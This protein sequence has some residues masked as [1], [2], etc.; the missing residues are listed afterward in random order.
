MSNS[1]YAV[2][3]STARFI[4]LVKTCLSKSDINVAVQKPIP[5]ALRKV[6]ELDN[7]TPDKGRLEK[8]A[9]GIFRMVTESYIFEK[10]A[11]GQ[12]LLSLRAKVR[13]FASTLATSE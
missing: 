13:E 9:I 12:E 8:G 11:L 5:S 6:S 7:D 3:I 1:P 4:S 10:S 2:C